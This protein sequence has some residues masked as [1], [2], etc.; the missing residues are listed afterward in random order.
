[1]QDGVGLRTMAQKDPLVEFTLE[2]QRMLGELWETVDF[3]TVKALMDP[4]VS[5]E[6][7][8]TPW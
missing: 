6:Q 2:S 5:G 4:A 7:T 3:E 8:M 1:M